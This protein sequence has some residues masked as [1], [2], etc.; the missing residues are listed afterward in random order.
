MKPYFTIT[1]KYFILSITCL[2]NWQLGPE[3]YERQASGGDPGGPGFPQGNPFGDIFGD[4]K[5]IV[6]VV[7]FYVSYICRK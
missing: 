7:L 4:V 5:T 3:A 2:C 6:L 1:V